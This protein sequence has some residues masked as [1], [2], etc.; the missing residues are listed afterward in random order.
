MKRWPVDMVGYK[1]NIGFARSLFE[2]IR[3][4]PIIT[5]LFSSGTN[6]A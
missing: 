1:T 3:K 2:F 6:S 5:C 4:E